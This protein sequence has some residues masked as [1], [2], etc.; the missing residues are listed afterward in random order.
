MCAAGGGTTSE[1]SEGE[2]PKASSRHW[3]LHQ[4]MAVDEKRSR[5]TA[6]SERTGERLERHHQ[7][8]ENS[9]TPG[10]SASGPHVND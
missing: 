6:A 10:T 3:L 8:C 9:A 4:K 7:S 1:S 2:P 5:H